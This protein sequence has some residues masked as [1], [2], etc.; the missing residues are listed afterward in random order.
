MDE[1]QNKDMFPKGLLTNLVQPAYT[2]I[3]WGS[4]NLNH[5]E[6]LRDLLSTVWFWS[7]SIPCK[8]FFCTAEGGSLQP[9]YLIRS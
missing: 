6:I 8:L 3:G 4:L 5:L 1:L 2:N 9:Q 7:S